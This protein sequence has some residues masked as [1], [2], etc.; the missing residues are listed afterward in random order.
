VSSHSRRGSSTDPS[1]SETLS[2]HFPVSSPSITI[3]FE[4]NTEKEIP[5]DTAWRQRFQQLLEYKQNYGNCKVPR[6]YS[7][8]PQLGN[9]VYTQRQNKRKGTLGVERQARLDLIG[10]E[11]G[12]KEEE[13]NQAA[14]RQR[15]QQLV[16]YKQTQGD[17]KVPY[18][19]SVNPHLGSWVMTQRRNKK[20]GRLDVERQARLDSIGFEWGKEEISA[21][22]AWGQRF[23]Q[24]VEYKQTHGD[25]KVP[26]EYSDNPQL[27][28][29]VMTQRRNKQTGRLDVERQAELDLIGFEWGKEERIPLE[30]AWKQR[31][32]QLVEYKQTH[33]D[34]RVPRQYSVNPQLGFWV[35]AQRRNKRKGTLGVERQAQLDSIGF[36]WGK[37]EE[38]PQY[39]AWRLV[40]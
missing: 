16:E 38:T 10:F 33:G 35:N 40:S 29:W 27:S 8:N 14:W 28:S 19:Y 17:C 9:W 39:T 11:W 20:T 31:F 34:C 15:F 37:E 22:V 5:Y 3:G 32:Q 30:I 26:N 12:K 24:L 6:K 2:T 13:I 36:E 1:I 25:C 23:Q 18:S 4:W 7:G 21:Q